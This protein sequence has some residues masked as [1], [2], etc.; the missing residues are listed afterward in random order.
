MR[1]AIYARVS[2]NDQHVENQLVEL[3]QYVERRGWT[4][5]EYVDE[6]VSGA[7]E[8]RPALD[9][10]LKAGKRRKFDVLLVFCDTCSR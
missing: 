1:C 6:G 3:R 2:T 4:G 7:K 10:M 5:V 9:H 8:R